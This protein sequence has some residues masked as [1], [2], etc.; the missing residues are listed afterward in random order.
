MAL[1]DP[2][3]LLDCLG[4]EFWEMQGKCTAAV[5]Y[6]VAKVRLEVKPE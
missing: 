5:K 3:E 1:L 2:K 6:P 4:R